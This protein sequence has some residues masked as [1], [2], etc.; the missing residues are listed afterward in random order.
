[1][2]AECKYEAAFLIKWAKLNGIYCCPAYQPVITIERK[3]GELVNA[4]RGLEIIHLDVFA[5]LL[6]AFNKSVGDATHF[7]RL[8]IEAQNA[9]KLASI[10]H[11]TEPHKFE[12]TDLI[13]WSVR[14]NFSLP[15]ELI[16]TFNNE[17]APDPRSINTLEKLVLGMA[18][19]SYDYDPAAEHNKATGTARGSIAERLSKYG[20]SLNDGTVRTALKLAAQK[21]LNKG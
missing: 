10:A 20:M 14:H 19:D 2:S 18:M 3:K 9:N 15:T 17:K 13:S 12:A 16:N 11:S 8:L 1:M 7:E 6:A 5:K 4:I 21:H